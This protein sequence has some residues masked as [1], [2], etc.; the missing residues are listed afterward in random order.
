MTTTLAFDVYGTLIDP[1]DVSTKLSE[2]VGD[3]ASQFAQ[4]WRDKQIEYLFRRGLMREYRDFFN[5]Y[6][7]GV[8]VYG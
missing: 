8:N 4:I 5:L 7:S 3:K 1:F 6:P 2:Y